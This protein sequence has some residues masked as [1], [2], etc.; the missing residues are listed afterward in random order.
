[1]AKKYME[2]TIVHDD[3]DPGVTTVTHRE[4]GDN[5]VYGEPSEERRYAAKSLIDVGW[6]TVKMELEV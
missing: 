6:V 5:G 1:M 3:T 2:L 4:A